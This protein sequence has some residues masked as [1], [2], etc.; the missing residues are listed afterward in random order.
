MA[1][2]CGSWWLVVGGWLHA[3]ADLGESVAGRCGNWWSL[4]L[5]VVGG[6]WLVVGCMLLLLSASWW[7]V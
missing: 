4:W 1:G 6:W 2:R 3:A 7:L 5:L